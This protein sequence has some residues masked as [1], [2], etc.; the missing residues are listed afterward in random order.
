MLP[1]RVV[2]VYRCDCCLLHF[3]FR[4]TNLSFFSSCFALQEASV[5]LF[6]YDKERIKFFFFFEWGFP[7]VVGTDP[8]VCE[9][10]LPLLELLHWAMGEK[11]LLS[12]LHKMFQGYLSSGLLLFAHPYCC[13]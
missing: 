10:A 8:V 6:G 7:V 13:K 9:A 1:L 2:W 3:E 11:C 4:L 12:R 5:G